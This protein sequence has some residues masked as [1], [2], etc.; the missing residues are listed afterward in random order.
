[1][2]TLKK[3]SHAFA[4]HIMYNLKHERHRSNGLFE[5]SNPQLNTL[6]CTVLDS[7]YDTWSQKVKW[8]PFAF[9]SQVRYNMNLSP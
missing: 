2:N 6:L 1:M 4:V 5:N 9:N 8:F 3:S 7:E